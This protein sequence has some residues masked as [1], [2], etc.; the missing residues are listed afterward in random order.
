VGTESAITYRRVVV[1]NHKVLGKT[2]DELQLERFGVA[3]TRMTRADIEVTAVPG[4]RLQFGD[5]LQIV[6]GEGDIDRAAAML[7]NSVKELNEVHFIPFFIGLAL[8]VI[9][10]TMPISVPGLPEPIRLGLAGGPL[11]V[12]LLLG[13]LGHFRGQVW[14]MPVNTNLA[15]REFGIVL[16]FAGVGLD[17]GPKFFHTVFSTIGFEWLIAGTVITILPIALA[18]AFA[19]AVWKMNFTDITGMLAGSMTSPPGLAFAVNVAESD[20][21]TLAY[22]TVYPL[23]TLLRIFCAQLLVILLFR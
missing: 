18:G 17:A 2:V 5:L 10:G 8:G 19:R 11:V 1:T 22:A 12:A 3:V 13:R 4:L 21:P 23:T 7:G 16:F 14:H 6:G 20:S 15:F 9:L